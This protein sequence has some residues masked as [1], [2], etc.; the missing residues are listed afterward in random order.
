M[1]FSRK[2]TGAGGH[3]LLQGISTIQGSNSHLLHLLNWQAASSPPHHMGA[4]TDI[5]HLFVCMCVQQIGKLRLYLHCY[6]LNLLFILL[7]SK[8]SG[9]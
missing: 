9:F 6:L 3:F 2:N 8:L 5:M 7:L 4:N 1:E